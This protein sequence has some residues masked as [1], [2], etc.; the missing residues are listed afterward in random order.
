[1][2]PYCYTLAWLIM[3]DIQLI[4][5][6]KIKHCQGRVGGKKNIGCKNQ[7]KMREINISQSNK[8]TEQASNL[9]H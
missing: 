9:A 2:T 3:Q 4:Q 5:Q 6:T 8:S 7:S 1:M